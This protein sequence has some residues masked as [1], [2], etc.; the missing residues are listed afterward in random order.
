M[1]SVQVVRTNF[2]SSLA[3]VPSRGHRRRGVRGEKT[4]T[5]KGPGP[6]F[7]NAS[8]DPPP[9]THP[10]VPSQPKDRQRGANQ[11]DQHRSRR[12]PRRPTP[13]NETRAP[14]EGDQSPAG[15][16]SAAPPPKTCTRRVRARSS[17][18]DL[19]DSSREVGKDRPCIRGPATDV[20]PGFSRTSLRVDRT[21]VGRRCSRP[22]T[23]G[24]AGT[25]GAWAPHQAPT[26]RPPETGPPVVGP[27]HVEKVPQKQRSRRLLWA[28]A[29]A[30]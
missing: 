27:R 13:R 22:Q 14:P 7:Q 19:S 4:D 6:F 1:R 23:S 3:G 21:S 18:P 8:P 2:S 17:G 5:G 15:R 30:A 11:P 20:C 28:R 12:N 29:P 9:P 26:R 25:C 10:L 16:R 24:A